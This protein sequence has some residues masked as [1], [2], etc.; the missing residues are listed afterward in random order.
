LIKLIRKQ[1]NSEKFG[2]TMGI[3]STSS[4]FG[5]LASGVV[6]GILMIYGFDW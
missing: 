6:Y 5:I 3:M 1:F 2:K 4:E